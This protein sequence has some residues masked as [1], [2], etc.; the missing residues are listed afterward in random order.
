MDVTAENAQQQAPCYLI[1]IPLEMRG[2]IYSICRTHSC[3]PT[4]MKEPRLTRYMVLRVRDVGQ[5]SLLALSRTCKQIHD[6]VRQL[7]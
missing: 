5:S 2:K 6:E 3:Y 1:R 7:D 4:E